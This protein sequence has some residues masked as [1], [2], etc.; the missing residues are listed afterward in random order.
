MWYRLKAEDI[1]YL[2]TDERFMIFSKEGIITNIATTRIMFVWW[3]LLYAFDCR[4]EQST[5]CCT[6]QVCYTMILLYIFSHID[7]ARVSQPVEYFFQF[8]RT[9][10]FFPFAMDDPFSKAQLAEAV[11][12]TDCFFA[13]GYDFIPPTSILDIT[14]NNMIVRL[15]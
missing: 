7:F 3:Y 5:P 15:Q 2:Y 6:L 13:E 8:I 10:F 11:E 1:S 9:A 12:H 14:L 4:V